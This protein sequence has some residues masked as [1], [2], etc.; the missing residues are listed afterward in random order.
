[1]NDAALDRA[2][3]SSPVVAL[4]DVVVRHGTRTVLDIAHLQIA[5]GERVGLIGPNGAGKSSLLRLLS[6]FAGPAQ[7]D[8]SVLGCSLRA[9]VPAHALSGLRAKLG[10]VMQGV[11]LVQ[12]LSALDNVLI[13]LL[14]RRSG[15]RT[16]ARCHAASDVAE[17]ERALA[18]VGL[19]ARAHERV[20]RL[21]GGER[22][23]VAIARVLLQQPRL[24]LADE[25]TA[26][27]DPLAAADVCSLLQK[28]ATG[29]TLV[30]V[31]HSPTL[32]AQLCDRVIG[33]RQGRITFDTALAALDDEQLGALYRAGDATAAPS[34]QTRRGMVAAIDDRAP[35][36]A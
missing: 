29:A 17:A 5:A 33:L 8:A 10:F 12:R 27:L 26:S 22:Q 36:T 25:P 28:A 18:A 3:A 7:G 32:L 9:P 1:M 11:H 24:I 30:T 6:G 23:K 20:D 16:W 34:H 19:L 15:W 35:A 31:V 4:R 2:A 21:S 14:G 13:G